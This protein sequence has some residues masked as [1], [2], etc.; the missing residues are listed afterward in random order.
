MAD[1]ITR[2]TDDRSHVNSIRLLS[3]KSTPLDS[4]LTAS[5]DSNQKRLK[6]IDTPRFM[7]GIGR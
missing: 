7:I 2:G 6:I 3:L 1:D 4:A 5:N